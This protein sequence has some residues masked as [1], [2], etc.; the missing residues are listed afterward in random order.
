[1][2]KFDINYCNNCGNETR[3]EIPEGD[4]KLRHVCC[5]CGAIH[6]QNPKIITGCLIEHNEKILLCKRG[7]EPQSGKWT[8]PAGFMEN[9]ETIEQG[10]ARETMEEA[11]AEITDMSLYAVYDIPHISQVYMM[12]RAQLISENFSPGI[13]SLEVGLFDRNTIPWELLA[14][15]VIKEVLINYYDDLDKGIFNIHTGII[16][17]EMKKDLSKRPKGF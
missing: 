17:A 4:Q 16:T 8:L 9:N 12:Y 5:Q 1:M 3:E 14:F 13:E 15:S 6:Y 10:A 7:I 11:N 2:F